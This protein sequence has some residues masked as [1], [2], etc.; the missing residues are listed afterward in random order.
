MERFRMPVVMI[1]FKFSRLAIRLVGRASVR[2]CRRSLVI[3]E[4]R[5]DGVLI[6]QWF[7]EN[8][9]GG[10]AVEGTPIRYRLRNVLIIVQ[11]RNAHTVPPP[12]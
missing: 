10:S 7:R 5:G 1:S 11:Y 6:A 9:D 2:A 8:I 4:G 12:W 3:G